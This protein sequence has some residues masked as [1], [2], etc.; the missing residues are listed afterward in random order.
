MKKH[1]SILIAFLILASAAIAQNVGPPFFPQTLPS[2]TV[3]GRTQAGTGPASAIPITGLGYA[4]LG[5][6]D[7]TLS[8]GA[9]IVS[10]AIGTVSSGTTTIDCGKGPLQ[11]LT[12]G[13]A[14]TL[15]APSLDGSCVVQVT[16]NGAAGT[17]T[18]SGFTT[19]S[20]FTGGS[21]DTTNTHKFMLNIV[22]VNGSSI[23]Q[24]LPQQ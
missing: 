17:I 11:Y 1:F 22:R 10:F 24:I 20:S 7:Q 12:N 15:A 9:N 13:G 19:N 8:G 5:A 6:Q 4:S 23:Y 18:F 14:F 16:N 2:G 3:V 21:L